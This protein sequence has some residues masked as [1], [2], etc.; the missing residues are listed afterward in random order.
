[1]TSAVRGRV[2]GVRIEERGW[3]ERSGATHAYQVESRLKIACRSETMRKRKAALTLSVL[4]SECG[5]EV[6]ELKLAHGLS[7][8]GRSQMTFRWAWSKTTTI[9]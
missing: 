1:M 9:G 6:M 8:N 5:R 2:L 7:G 3:A 4:V